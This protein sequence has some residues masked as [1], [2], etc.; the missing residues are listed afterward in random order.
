MVFT[1]L[2]LEFRYVGQKLRGF[3]CK[4]TRSTDD[5]LPESSAQITAQVLLPY[6]LAGL[7]MVATGMIMETLQHWE[8]FK[9]ISE[10]FILV[11]AL[12]GL[13]GNLEMTLAS[14]LSTAVQATVVGFLATLAAAVLGAISRNRV[15]LQQSA[16]LLAS[17]VTTAFTAALTLGLVMVGVI[18]G[19]R[20][21]GINPDNVATPIAASLGDLM[22]LSLLAG[23][24]RFFFQFKELWCVSIVTCAIFL[25]LIPIWLAIARRNPAIRE[26]LRSVWHPVIAAMLIS[27]AGG[28]ILDKTVSHP[29]FDGMAVFTPIING[30]GGNLVGI[31]ASRIS[32]YLHC[33]SL[34]GILPHSMK[35]HCPHPGRT[36]CS[37]GVNSTSARV[38]LL[39]VIPGHLLFLYTVY[40]L[41]G[42]HSTMTPAFICCYLFAALMQVRGQIGKH[43]DTYRGTIRCVRGLLNDTRDHLC[44]YFFAWAHKS[45]WLLPLLKL[46]IILI[47]FNSHSGITVK[48]CPCIMSL[49]DP[50]CA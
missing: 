45:P 41:Q 2:E 6:L 8:M 38:L 50:A 44:C 11:P 20:K 37:S 27:S 4:L 14:R 19:S 34:P 5:Y 13:K 16:V 1:H 43:T 32:T 35:E 7:S 30:V 3:T 24:G 47:K 40:W 42:G 46:H 9:E 17:G 15:D 49:H 25:L 21:V 36:F 23:I 18:T 33:V 48:P 22:T 39:L 29:Q 31:Q 26:V 10:V 12:V 28:L